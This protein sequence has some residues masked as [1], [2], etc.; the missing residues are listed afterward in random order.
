VEIRFIPNRGKSY[1]AER[2]LRYTKEH[3]A[4]ACKFNKKKDLNW[5]RHLSSVVKEWN[6]RI[7]PKT[8]YRRS[9]IDKTNFLDFL[10]QVHGTKDP[11]IMMNLGTSTH[12]SPRVQKALWRYKLG[13]R[14]V[15]LRASNYQV[16]EK[17]KTWHK[18]SEEGRFGTR[19]YVISKLV[20][21]RD[22][23]MKLL[24]V[25]QL[26]NEK[27]EPLSGLWYEREIKKISFAA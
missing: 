17:T 15:L 8:N 11:D 6:G 27:G 9:T 21:K 3:V 10:G 25:Y 7:V 12:H 14:V 24:P 1:L 13:D 23:D 26:V 22:K 16:G 2:Y 19:Q 18:P 4:L 20:L 5:T